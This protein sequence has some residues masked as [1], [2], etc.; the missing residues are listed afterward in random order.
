MLRYYLKR[1]TM[2]LGFSAAGGGV[3]IG[4]GYYAEVVYYA[5]RQ[6]IHESDYINSHIGKPPYESCKFAGKKMACSNT[7]ILDAFEKKAE[8]EAKNETDSER[9]ANNNGPFLIVP[10]VICAIAGGI[11]STRI[12][13]QRP[14]SG[15][16]LH[17][18]L[19]KT[20]WL[21]DPEHV[22]PEKYLDPITQ[23]LMKNPQIVNENPEWLLDDSSIANLVHYEWP[24]SREPITSV[25]P[26]LALKKEIE[27]WVIDKE[28]WAA[29]RDMPTLVWYGPTLFSASKTADNMQAPLLE[30]NNE[31]SISIT[32][33]SNQP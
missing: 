26:D 14:H 20:K 27:E 18:R 22:I 3:G 9:A 11:V 32:D 33:N 30:N 15:E 4:A 12:Y 13:I 28:N 25:T 17:D 6:G 16:A 23:T 8:K 19:L 10:A 24:F 7:T 21:D 31:I 2:L 1:L 5:S 29:E